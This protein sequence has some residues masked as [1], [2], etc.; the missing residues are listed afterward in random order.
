LY[1][2]IEIIPGN[3]NEQQ[4]KLINIWNKKLENF[5]K[6]G[7]LDD[8]IIIKKVKDKRKTIVGFKFKLLKELDNQTQMISMSIEDYILLMVKLGINIKLD[9]V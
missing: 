3:Y 8:I 1:A 4:K 7:T 9:E 5:K 6:I 2:S